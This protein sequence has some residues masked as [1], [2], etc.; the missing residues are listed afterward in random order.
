[1]ES[2]PVPCIF[3]HSHQMP[4]HNIFFREHEYPQCNAYDAAPA[5]GNQ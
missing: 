2:S 5:L 1:M 3:Y 4:I